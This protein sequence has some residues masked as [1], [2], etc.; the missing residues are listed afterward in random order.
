[1]NAATG[2][3][4][5]GDSAKACAVTLAATLS[6]MIVITG[7]GVEREVPATTIRVSD[8]LGNVPRFIYLA[9]G[10]VIETADNSW[11]DGILST[12]RRGRLAGL[13]HT[14]ESHQG[15]AAAG[16]VV[17]VALI[18]LGLYF[19]PPR[20]ARAIAGRVPPAIEA[21]AGTVALASLKRFF[22][23]ST[24]PPRSRKMAELQLAR[25]L[26]N[27]PAQDRPR[28]EFRVMHHDYPNAF[29]LPGNI[30][31]VTDGLMHLSPT[32]DELAAV[33][34]HELGHL[35]LHHGMQSVLRNSFALLIVSGVTGDL[36]TLTSFAAALP[37][38]ILTK[39]YSRDLER[40]ADQY[41]RDLLLARKIDPK[42]ASAILFKM[43]N[44][45]GGARQSTYLS[46]HPSHGER[47]QL[48]GVLTPK[49]MAA[50][51]AEG[52]SN[53][54]LT[55]RVSPIYPLNARINRREARV[56][57]DFLVDETGAVQNAHIVSAGDTEFE[58]QALAAVKQ[59]RFTP[60]KKDFR[61]TATHMQVPIVFSLES[62][63]PPA[64]APT[65]VD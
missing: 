40:E 60:G 36:S 42:N 39:G 16:C 33:L 31:V 47:Q 23:A 43:E 35:Q 58:T 26:P 64:P 34:A 54:K 2:T 13:I 29:A 37:V 52:A 15:L 5:D 1:M 50:I 48:F 63:A 32:D 56:I 49:E 11:V 65:V 8:R 41:G 30:I 4:F 57:V 38:S 62:P 45:V 21:R 55:N 12:Q 28:L 22:A 27:T 17:L 61:V 7:P 3:Y 44:V 51:R 18:A 25:L 6:G 53:P 9:E 20:L 59:W 19:G 14:L 10:G 24:L 46:T